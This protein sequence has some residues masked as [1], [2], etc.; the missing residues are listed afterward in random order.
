MLVR[1]GSTQYVGSSTTVGPWANQNSQAAIPPGSIQLP[2]FCTPTLEDQLPICC[3]SVLKSL[4]KFILSITQGPTIW[5]PGLLGLSV[6]PRFVNESMPYQQRLGEL[7]AQLSHQEWPDGKLFHPACIF[8]IV[9]ASSGTENVKSYGNWKC[10][11]V[12]KVAGRVKSSSYPGTI[13]SPRVF[14]TCLPSAFGLSRNV[15][16]YSPIVC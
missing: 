8:R 16:Q 4:Y 10:T 2:D 6:F 1:G 9:G 12:W 11:G 7:E 15:V 14:A 3:V 13:I 5:V